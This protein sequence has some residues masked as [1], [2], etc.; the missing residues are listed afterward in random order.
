M[1]LMI[2]PGRF[3]PVILRKARRKYIQM[4]SRNNKSIH[5]YFVLTFLY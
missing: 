1:S 4:K 5:Y 3:S 2:K